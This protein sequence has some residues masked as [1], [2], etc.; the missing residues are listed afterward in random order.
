VRALDL[1]SLPAVAPQDA[2]LRLLASPGVASKRWVYPSVTTRWCAPTRWRA[3]GLTAGVV[4]VKGD[5][6]RAGDLHRRQRP[7][8]LPEPRRGAMLAVAEAARNGRLPRAAC[9]SGRPNCLNFGN[10][11]RPRSL[12]QLVEGIEG[13]ADACLRAR[14]ADHRRQRQPLQRDRTARPSIPRRSSGSSGLIDEASRVQTRTFK[15]AGDAVIL[16]GEGSRGALRQRVPEDV[17]GSFA[18]CPALDLAR[19]PR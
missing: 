8:L 17:H 2:L 1:A 14:R 13:I 16:L 10:P 18:G 5:G 6:P 11:Q 7:L 3:A 15:G 4:R 9:R 19:E 12:W